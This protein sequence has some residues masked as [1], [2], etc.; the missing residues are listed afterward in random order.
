MKNLYVLILLFFSFSHVNAQY[1]G[2]IGHATPQGGLD[3]NVQAWVDEI[4]SQSGTAPSETQLTNISIMV[5]SLKEDGIWS[6]RDGFFLYAQDGS[7]KACEINLVDPGGDLDAIEYGTVNWVSDTGVKTRVTTSTEG[8][9]DLNNEASSLTY[10]G[11]SDHGWGFTISELDAAD[12]IYLMGNYYQ[13]KFAVYFSGSL[14]RPMSGWPT[15]VS[16]T[17]LTATVPT[18]FLLNRTSN[19]SLKTYQDGSLLATQTV[20]ATSTL[21]YSMFVGCMRSTH[22][23]SFI[24]SNNGLGRIMIVHYGASMSDTERSDYLDAINTYLDTL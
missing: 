15:Y 18:T 8:H 11:T 7:K 20:T 4:E 2:V 6:S 10:W 3:A 21:D 9:Y 5:K 24:T 19:V 16:G 22:T 12:K 13:G 17:P 23:G 1:Y 14:V